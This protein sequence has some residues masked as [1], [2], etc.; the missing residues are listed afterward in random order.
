VR[1]LDRAAS[2]ERSHVVV[3][4]DCC[5]GP[6]MD[7]HHQEPQIISMTDCPIASLDEVLGFFG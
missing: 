5:A 7:L 4:E 1:V 3:V 6:T 2:D